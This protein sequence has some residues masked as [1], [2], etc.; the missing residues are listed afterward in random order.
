[1]V[2]PGTPDVKD[3]PAISKFSELSFHRNFRLIDVKTGFDCDVHKG[4]TFAEG[5]LAMLK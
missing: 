1:V 5:K 3:N 2:A 4:N